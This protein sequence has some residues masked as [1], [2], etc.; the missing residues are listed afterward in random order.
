MNEFDCMINRLNLLNTSELETLAELCQTK[1]DAKK[2]ARREGLRQELMANL[3][4]AIDAILCN[5]FTL[6][7]ENSDDSNWAVRLNPDDIYHIEIE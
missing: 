6:T 5:D 2:K 3:Q 7:I 4:Q 1:A